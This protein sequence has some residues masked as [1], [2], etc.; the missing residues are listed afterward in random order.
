MTGSPSEPPSRPTALRAES[1]AWGFGLFAA[2]RALTIA[3]DSLPLAASMAQ[4]VLVDWCASRAGLASTRPDI[5][6]A[7][8]RAA[9]GTAVGFSVSAMIA[10]TL[11]LTHSLLV[12]RVEHLEVSVL[13]LGLLTA[14][15]TAWRDEIVL[16]GITLRAL[17]ATSLSAP[18]RVLACG[19][20]SAGAAL[21]ESGATASTVASG[22]LLGVIFGSL[23][24]PGKPSSGAL[25]PW[26]A[27]TALRWSLDTLLLGGLAHARLSE[28]TWAGGSAGFLA[29]A[30][31]TVAVAPLSFAAVAW[32][33]ATISP[34]RPRLG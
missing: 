10:A 29:G 14:A 8:A 11:W 18:S 21:G 17:E 4:A 12:E 26:A 16:H 5:R 19:I 32:T 27:H 13:G 33:L 24:Q 25:A 6:T 28:G 3:L 7:I 9:K 23:W 34:T 20:T 15:L 30:A 31:A 22:M 1:A 2:C